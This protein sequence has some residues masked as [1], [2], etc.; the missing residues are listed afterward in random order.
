MNDRPLRT[1]SMRLRTQSKQNKRSPDETDQACSAMSM[2]F[3]TFGDNERLQRLRVV[4]VRRV[5]CAYSLRTY[6]LVQT[7]RCSHNRRSYRDV[8]P[9]IS[10]NES[11]HNTPKEIWKMKGEMRD[12]SNEQRRQL[13]DRCATGDSLPNRS[14]KPSDASRKLDVSTPCSVDTSLND[15]GYPFDICSSCC[16]ESVLP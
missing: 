6:T 12:R 14:I 9:Q 3:R 16:F 1:E 13:R 2:I 4:D 15:C 5:A 7:A 11:E 10:L 8:R